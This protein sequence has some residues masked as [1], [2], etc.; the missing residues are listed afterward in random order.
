[1]VVIIKDNEKFEKLKQTNFYETF[2]SFDE[3]G[4]INFL[5]LIFRY[6]YDK[7][8]ENFNADEYFGQSSDFCKYLYEAVGLENVWAMLRT[9]E[10]GGSYSRDKYSSLEDV[11]KET[12]Q[13]MNNPGYKTSA[14]KTINIDKEMYNIIKEK[15]G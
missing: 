1:M 3:K 15:S 13:A 12:E 10:T 7:D 2:T 14:D 4:K 11:I 8:Y 6:Y 9:V 5:G